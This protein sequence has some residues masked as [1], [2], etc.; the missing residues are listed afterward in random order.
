MP[1]SA[2]TY[3]RIRNNILKAA[4]RRFQH[5][6]Y[7]KTNLSEIAADVEMSTGNLYR[8]F[9]NKQAIA[10]ACCLQILD[11]DIEQL[12]T[13]LEDP[14]LTAAARLKTYAHFLLTHS[15][16]VAADSSRDNELIKF[17]TTSSSEVINHKFDQQLRILIDILEHG[18][19]SGDLAIDD[20]EKTA[21]AIH[22]AML[23]LD[24]PDL[25]QLFSQTEWEGRIENLLTLIIG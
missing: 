7:T 1:S 22:T 13:V 9:P 15:Q 8:Y 4:R 2:S 16:S 18:Q 23:I 11:E 21:V 10:L 25:I 17:M 24:V 19:I 12:R 3:H 5:Y 20:V 6:G 14:Q